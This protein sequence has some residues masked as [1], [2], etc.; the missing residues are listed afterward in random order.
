MNVSLL[1]DIAIVVIIVAMT[2]VGFRSG[3][4]KAGSSLVGLVLGVAISIPVVSYVGK[5]IAESGPR[6]A[7]VVGLVV[8][9]ANVG[10]V[11]GMLIGE[12]LR[13]RVRKR[14]AIGADRAAGGVVSALVAVLSVWTLAL[15]LAASALP[16]VAKIVRGSSILPVIDSIMPDGARTAY[17]AIEAALAD[18][19]LPDVLAPLQQTEVADVGAPNTGVIQDPEVLAASGSVVKVVGDAPQCSRQINGSG[20]VYADDRVVTNAHVVAGTSSMSIQT[21]SQTYDASVVYADEGIDVAILKVDG[22]GLPALPV[23]AVAPDA[24]SDAIVAGYPGGG[25]MTLG[26]AKVRTTGDISGP[27]FR[28]TSTVTRE[29]VALRGTVVGGNSGGPLLDLDG[30]VIGLVFAAAVDEADV[31]YALSVDQIDEALAAGENKDTNVVT[32]DCYE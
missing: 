18:Q 30:E 17:D 5:Q 15:P 24:G 3:L 25:P 22:L 28:H 19:G 29:V 10:Y 11:S 9:L 27:N 26:A 20:F 4:V 21:A 14:A 6:I 12:R 7:V 2:A 13:N 1:V 31:G 16:G 32:G 23:D 8:L